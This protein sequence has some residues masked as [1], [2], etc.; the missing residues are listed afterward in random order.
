MSAIPVYKL[1]LEEYLELDKNSE[2]RYEFFDGEVFAWKRSTA[3][4]R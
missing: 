4:C 1:S 2:E 3:R